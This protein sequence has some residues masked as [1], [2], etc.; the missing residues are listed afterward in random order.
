MLICITKLIVC[1]SS[2]SQLSKRLYTQFRCASECNN[3][4]FTKLSNSE[5]MK[6]EKDLNFKISI[7]DMWKPC[8]TWMAQGPCRHFLPDVSFCPEIVIWLLLDIWMKHRQKST[9]LTKKEVS[10]RLIIFRK[11]I[12]FMQTNCDLRKM[13]IGNSFFLKKVKKSRTATKTQLFSGIFLF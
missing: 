6:K 2:C 7:L 3:K 1:L 4:S 8:W 10:Y 13:L 11:S 12:L 9:V 5:I